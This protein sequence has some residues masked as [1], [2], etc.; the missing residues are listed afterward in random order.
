MGNQNHAIYL[1]RTVEKGLSTVRHQQAHRTRRTMRTGKSGEGCN[2]GK[3]RAGMS[4][5]GRE[6]GMEEGGMIAF[7]EEGKIY[8]KTTTNSG[9]IYRQLNFLTTTSHRG[10]LCD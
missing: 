4:C 10:R 7:R 8:A 9:K 3:R 1:I 6:K 5:G 2:G